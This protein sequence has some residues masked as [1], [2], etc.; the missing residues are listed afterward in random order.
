MI[1]EAF[2][3][4]VA[5]YFVL[6][7]LFLS[8][9]VTCRRLV[10]GPNLANRVVAL[11]LMTSIGIG[12]IAIYAVARDNETLLDITLVTALLAFLSTVGFS[13]YLHQQK[14]GYEGDAPND[15]S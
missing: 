13:Y 1:S 11:D 8:V 5:I 14:R 6:P 9:V 7:V 10:K 3:Q 4:G 12:I 15:I 2:I